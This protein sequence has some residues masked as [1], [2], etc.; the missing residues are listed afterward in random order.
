[1]TP[2]AVRVTVARVCPAGCKEG[3]VAGDPGTFVRTDQGW[4]LSLS[5]CPACHGRGVVDEP[6]S[7]AGCKHY[8]SQLDN[9][10]GPMS[11]EHGHCRY[12]EIGG[13]SLEVVGEFACS[14]WEPREPR[15]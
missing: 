3:R 4:K 14:A 10:P 12:L 5:V 1:M 6:V 7:C 2:G 11:Q 8:V 13:D 9:T 15:S